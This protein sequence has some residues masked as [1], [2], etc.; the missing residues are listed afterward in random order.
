MAELSKILSRSSK[1]ETFENPLDPF[2]TVHLGEWVMVEVDFNSQKRTVTLT[3]FFTEE[4]WTW[5][6]SYKSSFLKGKK[7][8]L[9]I[10]ESVRAIAIKT[11]RVLNQ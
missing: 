10:K 1:L 4:S 9:A 7:R 6:F 11:S 2:I 8:S 3:D 5:D